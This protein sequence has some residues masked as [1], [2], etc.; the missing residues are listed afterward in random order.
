LASFS[1]VRPG[2]VEAGS[3]RIKVPCKKLGAN[4]EEETQ[5]AALTRTKRRP[6]GPAVMVVWTGS[7]V[8]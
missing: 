3:F 2:H 8:A 7:R 1:A 5:R 4:L 6:F